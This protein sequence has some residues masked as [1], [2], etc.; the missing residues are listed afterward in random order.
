MATSSI[1]SSA[2]TVR[3]APVASHASQA[4]MS[5]A[6]RMTSKSSAFLAGRACGM[7]STSGVQ[8]GR[9]N[10]QCYAKGKSSN[11][12]IPGKTGNPGADMSLPPLDPENPQ[13]MIYVRSKAVPQWYPVSVVT[14]GSAAKGLIK[15]AEGNFAAQFGSDALTRNVGSVIYKDEQQIRSLVIRQYPLLKKAKA[16][17]WGYKVLDATLDPK[18]QLMSFAGVVKIPEESELKAPVEKAADKVKSL[19]GGFGGNKEAT[20]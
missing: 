14:G 10:L 7:T 11:R 6:P 12:K 4:R 17:E 1:I 3:V 13:F 15:M 18:K 8:T 5:V 9:G 19:F 2:Q 20:N 16:L